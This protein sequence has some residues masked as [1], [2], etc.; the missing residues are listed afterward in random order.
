[1]ATRSRTTFQK[2]QKEMA[3]AEKQRDKAAKRAQRKTRSRSAAVRKRSRSK[4][5]RSFVRK[6]ALHRGSLC[7]R[8]DFAPFAKPVSPSSISLDYRIAL[9]RHLQPMPSA[10]RN[11]WEIACG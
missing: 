1:M 4:R 5:P 3:R 7:S 2:R 8:E 9:C 11:A 6:T 10:R